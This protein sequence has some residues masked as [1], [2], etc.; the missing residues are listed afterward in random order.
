MLKVVQRNRLRQHR[1]V[2]SKDDY[3]RVKN[4]LLGRLMEPDKEA[5]PEKHGK[6][7]WIRI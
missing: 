3:E 6:R 1:H 2:L 4:V 5:G 7:L